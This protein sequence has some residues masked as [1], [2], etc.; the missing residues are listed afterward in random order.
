MLLWLVRWLRGYVIFSVQGS[1]VEKFLNRIA[2]EEFPVWKIIG[3]ERGIVAGTFLGEYR[4]LWHIARECRV[5]LRVQKRRGIP[6]LVGDL[7][8]RPGLPVGIAV[9]F[10]VI[11]GLSFFV[12]DIRV[13][14]L[15]QLEESAVL[16]GLEQSGITLGTPFRE[17]DLTRLEEDLALALPEIGWVTA[18]RRGSTLVIDLREKTAVPEMVPTDQPCNIKART[19][20]QILTI[21]ALHGKSMVEVGDVVAEGEL[22]I[23]GVWEGREGEMYTGHASG[24][25]VARTRR[26]VTEQILLEEELPRFTGRVL[27]RKSLRLFGI[28]VPLNLVWEPKEEAE[29]RY[30]RRT[31]EQPLVC[32]GTRLPLR[33]CRETWAEYTVQRIKRTREEAEILLR[34]RLQKT[35][36]AWESVTLLRQE[37]H[38]SLEEGSLILTAVCHCEEEI[39]QE[40]ELLVSSEKS[41][42]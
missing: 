10:A 33:F 32:M 39:G 7:R 12:W 5:R 25:V 1:H 27:Q 22:L 23:S 17:V 37:E 13:L 36:T 34:E 24:K 40:E 42:K 16:S 28:S 6:F 2:R 4:R 41:E 20:G 30:Q 38:W 19:S 14:G 31:D 15:E 18:Y 8:K 35:V 29:R 9:F 21:H 26:I 3:T 11:L